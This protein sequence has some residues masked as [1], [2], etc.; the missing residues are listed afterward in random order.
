M[1]S[2]LI[3]ATLSLFSYDELLSTKLGSRYI[4]WEG[5]IEHF[6]KVLVTSPLHGQVTL[7]FLIISSYEWAAVIKLGQQVQL[8]EGSPLGTILQ[9]VKV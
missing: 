7:T 6:L 5:T 3:L 1:R 9:V 8:L 4:F 2:L